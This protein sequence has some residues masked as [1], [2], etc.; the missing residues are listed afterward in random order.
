MVA[1]SGE[2]LTLDPR[3]QRTRQMLEQAFIDLLREKSFQ[4]ISV[5]DVTARAGLNRGT[6]YD[7]FVDKY[8]FLEYII[9]TVY[10]QWLQKKLPQSGNFNLE[11]VHLLV[12]TLCEMM[13]QLHNRCVPNDHELLRRFESQVTSQ[14]RDILLQWL[15]VERGSSSDNDMIATIISW[16]IYGA[17][18]Y[19]DQNG[20]TL[21]PQ[22]Y[23][24]RVLPLVLVKMEPEGA[25]NGTDN[26]GSIV[27]QETA[28]KE[29]ELYRLHA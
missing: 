6:F 14:M 20:Q 27:Y 7:H 16:S 28:K 4:S 18:Q 19:W 8:D 17:A 23:A 5:Q 25:L 2:V 24:D 1:N 21:S 3:A 22:D 11:N 15:A 29:A 13:Q 26:N 10:S 12:V 9:R